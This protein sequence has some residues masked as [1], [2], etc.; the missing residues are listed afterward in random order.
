MSSI[1]GIGVTADRKIGIGLVTQRG[2]LEEWAGRGEGE[3]E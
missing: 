2:N 1:S 3:R